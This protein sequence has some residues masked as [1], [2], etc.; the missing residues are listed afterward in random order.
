VVLESERMIFL[1][2]SP[3]PNPQANPATI[4]AVVVPRM[5]RTMA[6]RLA[7]SA[8]WIATSLVRCETRQEITLYIPA[9]AIAIVSSARAPM[10]NT[11]NR[12]FGQRVRYQFLPRRD[13]KYRLVGIRGLNRILHQLHQL[14]RRYRRTHDEVDVRPGELPR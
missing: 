14:S 6:L 10:R 11:S 4:Q 1:P 12:C 3:R 5:V 2:M 8:M 9:A 7:P 13:A